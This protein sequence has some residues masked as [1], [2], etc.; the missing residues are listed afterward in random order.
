MKNPRYKYRFG[1]IL[2]TYCRGIATYQ[3]K[4]LLRQI[5]V[6][7]KLT[8]LAQHVKS[9][10]DSSLSLLKSSFLVETLKRADYVEALSNFMSPL[11]RSHILGV[12]E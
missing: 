9:N 2:E 4:E 1:L 3:L 11:N 7:E 10:C 6:V 12:I 8:N 5:E